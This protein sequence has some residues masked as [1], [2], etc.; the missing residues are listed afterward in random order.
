[1]V[2]VLVGSAKAVAAFYFLGVVVVVFPLAFYFFSALV[3]A[4]LR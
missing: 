4:H 3:I 1:M 2:I